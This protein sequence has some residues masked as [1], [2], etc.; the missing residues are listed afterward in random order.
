MKIYTGD[1]IYKEILEYSDAKEHHELSDIE[2]VKLSSI[3][4]EL[5]FHMQHYKKTNQAIYN[6]INSFYHGLSI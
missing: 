2:F 1:E 3:E 4:N 6:F 5:K